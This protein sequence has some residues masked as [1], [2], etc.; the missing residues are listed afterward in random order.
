MVV[1][2]LASV[3]MKLKT[4]SRT[5]IFTEGVLCRGNSGDLRPDTAANHNCLCGGGAWHQHPAAQANLSVFPDGVWSSSSKV[6]AKSQSPV[7][8]LEL[9][10]SNSWLGK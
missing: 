9:S 2:R 3:H 7:P 5:N 8:A 1:Y 10:F 4:E 6:R